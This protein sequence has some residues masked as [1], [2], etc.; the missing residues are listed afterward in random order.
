MPDSKEAGNRKSFTTEVSF[1]SRRQ[2][3]KLGGAGLAAMALPGVAGCGSEDEGSGIDDP[4]PDAE[5]RIAAAEDT[6]PGQGE[7]SESTAF[8]YPLNVNVYEPLVIL[9]SDYSLEPGLAESWELTS[10]DTWRFH[11]RRGVKF[12]DGTDFNAD[13]VIWSW[14]ERQVEGQALSTV[15]ATLGPDSVQ[16]VD[17]YTVDFTPE[18]PNLRLPEQIVHPSGAIVPEGQHMDSDPPVGTG[19]FQVVDYQPNQSVAVER[20]DDYWGDAPG[21]SRLEFRFL[22]DPQTRMQALQAGE[23]DFVLDAPPESV[24]SVEQDDGLRVVSSDPGREHLIYINKTGEPPYDL[25]EDANIRQAVSLA[26]D[27][28]AYVETVFEG[29]AE[30]GRWMSPESVLGEHADL[31]EPVPYDPEEARSILEQDGWRVGSDDIRV[32]DD[33]RLVLDLLGWTEVSQVALQLLQAQLGEVGI[34]VNINRAPDMATYGNLYDN[35]EFDLDLEVPNQNDGNPAFLPVLRMYSEYEGTERFAP[36]GEF[37]TWAERALSAE[38]EDEV[39]RASA[40]MMRILI[41]EE[42]IVVP[43]AGVFRIYA[44]TSDTD[45]RDPHPSQTNQLWVSLVKG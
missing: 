41:N 23:V 32:K 42:Y 33:R 28:E 44:M 40:E 22:P 43:L 29:N 1:L 4:D 15:A 36:G 7:G 37:D 12:H 26:I 31:V 14:G 24:S 35:T 9:G 10:S 21:A 38:T 30:P 19:P 3:L 39:Q 45:L 16:K 34:E 25:G 8:A 17:D 11:L 5:V 18:E 20:F 13:D 6:W 27:R 2:F